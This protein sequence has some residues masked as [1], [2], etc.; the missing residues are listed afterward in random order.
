[1]YILNFWVR[2]NPVY[3]REK[4]ILSMPLISRWLMSAGRGVL[5]RQLEADR[6][7]V[8]AGR[9]I[10]LRIL[11]NSPSINSSWIM[12]AAWEEHWIVYMSTY[13][14][15]ILTWGLL[16]TWLCLIGRGGKS[17]ELW[18]KSDV[19]LPLSGTTAPSLLPRIS[20][21]CRFTERRRGCSARD[22]TLEG[23]Q[24]LNP[25]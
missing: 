14:D 15:S 20:T 18:S 4:P 5:V 11:T 1:M 10:Q 23:R 25:A 22:D 16:L 3:S 24:K 7:A 6:L 19:G 12:E 8:V 2:P 9:L 21:V 17:F 13:L